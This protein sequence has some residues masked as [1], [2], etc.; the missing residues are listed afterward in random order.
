MFQGLDQ[1]AI[2]PD[3]SAVV[4]RVRAPEG[5]ADKGEMLHPALLDAGFQALISALPDDAGARAVALDVADADAV[6]ASLAEI[7]AAGHPLRGVVHAAGVLDDG[8]VYSLTAEQLAR[9]MAPKATG[10]W[11]L[12]QATRDLP[13]ESPRGR[14]ART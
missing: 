9:V 4:A 2:V 8:P 14:V 3:H 1:I 6:A 12:H 5:L 11:N 13:L 10:A 7:A